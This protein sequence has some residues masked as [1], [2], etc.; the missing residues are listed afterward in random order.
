MKKIVTLVVVGLLITEGGFAQLK[1]KAGRQGLKVRHSL[2]VKSF[3]IGGGISGYGIVGTANFSQF[4]RDNV[5]YKIGGGYEFKASTTNTTKYSS[6][7]GDVL[8]GYT[9]LDKGTLFV[10]GLGGITGAIDNLTGIQTDKNIKGGAFG[11]VIGGEIE[12]YFANNIV[13]AITGTQRVMLTKENSDRW[14]LT[15]GLR[16]KL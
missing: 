8:V 4:L 11:G 3:D 9:L 13:F 14:Y 12:C 1:K 2:G 15:A 7:F 5:F 10:N 6:M 16:F